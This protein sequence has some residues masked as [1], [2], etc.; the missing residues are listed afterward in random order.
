MEPRSFCGSG[1]RY[2]ARTVPTSLAIDRSPLRGVTSRWSDS[3]SFA[4]SRHDAGNEAQR[5]FSYL[6][7]CAW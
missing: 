6:K 2:A 3:R 5:H 4:Q 1:G 7:V